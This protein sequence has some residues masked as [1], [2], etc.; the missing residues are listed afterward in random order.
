MH[1][2]QGGM[3]GG[4]GREKELPRPCSSWCAVVGRVLLRGWDLP[5]APLRPPTRALGLP[6]ACLEKLKKGTGQGEGGYF[7]PFDGSLLG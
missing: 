2:V 6:P 1:R 7:P 5:S 3:R 4:E